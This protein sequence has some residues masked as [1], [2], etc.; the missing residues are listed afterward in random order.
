M[1]SLYENVYVDDDID[2]YVD[3]KWIGWNKSDVIPSTFQQVSSHLIGKLR[4]S[5]ILCIPS[6]CIDKEM[7][8]MIAV[9][10]ER[11]LIVSKRGQVA[12]LAFIETMDLNRPCINARRISPGSLLY[13]G[14][15]Y[16]YAI[17]ED[18]TELSDTLDVSGV[19]DEDFS[20]IPFEV[21][22]FTEADSTWLGTVEDDYPKFYYVPDLNTSLSINPMLL[23]MSFERLI[24]LNGCTEDCATSNEPNLSLFETELLHCRSVIAAV[25]RTKPQMLRVVSSSGQQAHSLFVKAALTQLWINTE[26]YGRDGWDLGFPLNFYI[27]V[28]RNSSCLRCAG[29]VAFHIIHE[30]Q[31]NNPDGGVGFFKAII[32]D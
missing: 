3:M 9:D 19:K 1:V 15:K 30:V 8:G 21:K 11:P 2:L 13:E 4:L 12:Y 29:K 20:T 26:W 23:W 18:N 32:I 7:L 27:T 5:K 14:Q 31:G 6:E 24:F 17:P 22:G 16:A 10:T 25:S 28:V